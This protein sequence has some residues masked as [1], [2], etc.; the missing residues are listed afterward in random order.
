MLAIKKFIQDRYKEKN[1]LNIQEIISETRAWKKYS[2][3]ITCLNIFQI[4]SDVIW[5]W[6]LSGVCINSSSLV[7]PHRQTFTQTQANI[8]TDTDSDK[9]SHSQTMLRLPSLCINANSD[10]A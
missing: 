1:P 5:F 3:C 6:L 9:N 2:P 4:K 7:V 8:R 10:W